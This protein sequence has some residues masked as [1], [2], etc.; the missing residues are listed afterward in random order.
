VARVAVNVIKRNSPPEK[1]FATV[2]KRIKSF[3]NIEPALKM[4]EP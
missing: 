4:V 3:D 1:S 2:Q